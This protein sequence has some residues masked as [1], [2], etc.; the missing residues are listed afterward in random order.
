[1]G[2]IQYRKTTR[3]ER[4]DPTWLEVGSQIGQLANIFSDRSDLIAYVGQGAGGLAPACYTP[5]T[6]EVE[7]NVDV[8]FGRGTTPAEI[9]DL[10]ERATQFEWPKATGA[11]FHEALHARF[12][13]WNIEQAHKDLQF[14]EFMALILLEEGRIEA[15]GVRI[16]PEN[17]G[18]LRACALE[19]VLSDLSEE[20]AGESDT[21]MAARLAA[22]ALARVDAGSV[23][24]DDVAGLRSAIESKLG[25]ERLEQLRQIWLAVQSY[26]NHH[27]AEGMYDLAREWARIVREASEENGESGEFGEFGEF[28]SGSGSGSEGGLVTPGGEASD[29]ASEFVKGLIEELNEAAGNAT[30]G[31]YG[32]LNDQQTSEEWKEEANS[33]A[34]DAKTDREAQTVASEVF[35][36]GTGPSEESRSR[37]SLVERRAPH[38]EERVAAVTVAKMLERAKYRERSE[39]EIHSVLP[40]GRLRTR[41]IVQGAALKS[42]GI[43]QQAEPWRRTARKHV[44]DPKLTIGVMV[45]IS[46][47]MSEAM[48]PMATTAWVMSEA[49]RRVQGKCAM[50]YYGNDVF[51]TLKPGQHLDEVNV[52]TAPDG[53]EEFNQAFKALNG[54]LNLTGG[55]GARLL[56]IVSDGCYTDKERAHARKTVSDCVRR[57]VGVLWLTFDNGYD[58]RL[59]IR[60]NNAVLLTGIV[61]P[62]AIATEIGSAAAKALTAVSA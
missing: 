59:A 51:P 57:G 23:E 16:M 11:I 60:D 14:D 44:D 43:M 8:A 36:K 13:L 25:T 33:R 17:A 45:D 12:S 5:A 40:P 27:N 26:D 37:S 1:M 21:N 4:T 41:A 19:I 39:T 3:A 30:I 7:V 15:T 54:A 46:G 42:K 34:K 28:G 2:H 53:T 10:R 32:Q 62:T 31:A 47:S 58:A 35:G 18:F 6:A 24:A 29:S 50:V 38:P 61:S 49:V 55:D 22:L 9:G 52:F 20:G 48:Q 56:V